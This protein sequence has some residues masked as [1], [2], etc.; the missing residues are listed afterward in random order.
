[1]DRGVPPIY[2][3]AIARDIVMLSAAKHLPT[4]FEA[5]QQ[6]EGGFYVRCQVLRCAQDDHRGW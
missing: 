4:Q 1:M 6:S 2:Q 5:V 3:N